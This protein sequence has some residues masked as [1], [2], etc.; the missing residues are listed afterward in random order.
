[1]RLKDCR[2]ILIINLGGIGD[3]LFST[4]ALRA[5]KASFP[6]IK[7]S[8]MV[9]ERVYEAVKDLR[10]IDEVII[11]HKNF[12]N[13]F[14]D[15]KILFVLRKKHFDLAIN[16]RTLVSARSAREIRLLFDIINPRTKVGRDTQGRGKFFDIKVPETDRGAKFEMEYDLE[17]VM[18]LG[19]KVDDKSVDF[20]IDIF[21]SQSMKM[22]LSKEGVLDSD[23]LVGIHPGGMPSRRWPIENFAKVIDGLPQEV[24]CKIVV[25]GGREEASLANKLSRKTQART[26][27]LT[28][29]LN[30]KELGALIKRCNLYISND[31]GPMHIA[32]ILKTPLVA[33]LGPGDIT[34]Y[35]PRNISDKAAVLY[36]KVVCAPCNKGRCN[37]LRCLK[38]ISPEE[39]IAAAI[40]VLKLNSLRGGRA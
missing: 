15:I 11:F 27:N 23:L 10:Y 2:N 24:W 22:I 18:A 6:Q 37:D 12:K 5:L 30:L 20:T 33:I 32:A 21:S 39:V 26:I 38:I 7:I 31:T 13:L 9:V 35:D 4:P 16:M 29:R 3:V 25:T 1:M 40:N 8:L 17:T 34:R 14:K 19:V 36:K 28:G